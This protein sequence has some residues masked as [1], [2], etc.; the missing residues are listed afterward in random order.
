MSRPSLLHLNGQ[1]NN[2]Q[3]ARPEQLL[4]HVTE[5]LRCH[6][7][8]VRFEDD[9]VF[10]GSNTFFTDHKADTIWKICKLLRPGSVADT[11]CHKI[12][13]RPKPVDYRRKDRRTGRGYQ[14]R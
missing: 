14:F 2:I 5:I 1:R 10:S 7:V 13:K 9:N 3:C 11:A 6:V 8:D 4:G 12:L